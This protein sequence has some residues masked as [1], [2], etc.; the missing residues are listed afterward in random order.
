MICA[1]EACPLERVRQ[2]I[3]AYR[4]VHGCTGNGAQADTIMTCNR[5]KQTK[6]WKRLPDGKERAMFKEEIWGASSESKRSA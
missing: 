4:E 1:D 3:N 6:G 2:S 5:C